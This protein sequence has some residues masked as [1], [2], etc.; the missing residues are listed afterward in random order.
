MMRYFQLRR[1]W[2]QWLGPLRRATTMSPPRWR[3]PWDHQLQQQQQQLLLLS[4]SFCTELPGTGGEGDCQT[5]ELGVRGDI[6]QSNR[7]TFTSSGA[8]SE[9]YKTQFKPSSSSSYHPSTYLYKYLLWA[10]LT[11][12]YF[13]LNKTHKSCEF[14]LTES[15]I[16]RGLSNEYWL[17]FCIIWSV[18]CC[19]LYTVVCCTLWTVCILP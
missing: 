5:G 15:D 11:D 8:G 12:C 4:F 7:V 6:W 3:C 9:R 10:V 13:A 14:L 18:Q 2:S 16:P 17:L 1:Q 19:V